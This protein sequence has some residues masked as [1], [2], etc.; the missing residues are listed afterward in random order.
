MLMTYIAGLTSF[1]CFAFYFALMLMLSCEPG[2]KA[3]RET[4]VKTVVPKL[5][6]YT[7]FMYC[8]VT[9]IA[10][11]T[12]LVLSFNFLAKTTSQ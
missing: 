11:Q 7:S 8:F 6:V 3:L 2:F 10:P 4:M 1:L 9:K 12:F 5:Y